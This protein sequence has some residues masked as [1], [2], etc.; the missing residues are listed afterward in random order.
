MA[1]RHN[2]LITPEIEARFWAKVDRS[3]GGPDDCWIWLG[4]RKRKSGGHGTFGVSNRLI[5]AAHQVALIISGRPRPQPPGDHGLHSCD[6]SACVNPRHLRW[7]T[8]QENMRDRTE[9]NL[10]FNRGPRNYASKLS[11]TE[12]AY[13]LIA[14][15]T[16]E[17]LAEELGVHKATISDIRCGKTWKKLR[18]GLLEQGLSLWRV[19]PGP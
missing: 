9:R 13:V 2:V 5:M 1:D 3:V 7:G 17:E 10:A 14:P 18:E 16:G 6:N 12:A 11:K 4:A 19:P 15:R 8:H